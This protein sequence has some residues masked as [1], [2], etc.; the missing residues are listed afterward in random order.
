MSA[1]AEPPPV[2]SRRSPARGGAPPGSGSPSSSAGARRGAD[3]HAERPTRSA[4]GH[5][6]GAQE[7]QPG[8]GP[9]ARA[10]RRT[11]EPDDR[12]GRR[13][14][15][16]SSG[17]AVVVTAP[18]GLLRRA[19]ARTSP[20]APARVVLVRPG[21]RAAAAIAA[22]SRAGA[23]RRRAAPSVLHRPRRGRRRSGAV[24]G[25]HD[26]L[27]PRRVRR[28]R[29]AYDNASADLAAAR[30]A[31]FG[32]RASQ[33]PSLRRGRRGH[34]RQRDHGQPPAQLRGVAAAGCQ[35]P[36][37]GD[38]VSVWDLF[39][40]GTVRVFWWTVA[41]GVLLVALAGA[42]AGQRRRRATACHRARCGTRRGPR[43][44]VRAGR[45]A[46]PRRSRVARGDPRPAR[47]PARPAGRGDRC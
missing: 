32:G 39:P 41:V 47:A 45:C 38:A 26:P 31:R 3:R 33:R 9:A 13:A 24:A 40:D 43:P 22:G 27:C 42:P 16:R 8:G 14:R 23:R 30:G 10:V 15:G 20:R 28:C 7:R 44:A 21:E 17:S 35:T 1:P 2:A 29:R 19:A 5:R 25:G 12:P 36:S 34:G 18:D 37:G 6:L 4:A 11:G 46:R